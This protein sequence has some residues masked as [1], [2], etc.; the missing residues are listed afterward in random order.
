MS[1]TKDWETR[2]AAFR[3]KLIDDAVRPKVV[4]KDAP[5]N[6]SCSDAY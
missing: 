3:A 1:P 6:F 5:T 4:A 2:L